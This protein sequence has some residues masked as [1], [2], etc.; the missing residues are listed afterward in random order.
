MEKCLKKAVANFEAFELDQDTLYELWLNTTER[1]YFVRQGKC[2]L[3]FPS[4][5]ACFIWNGANKKIC[6][7]DDWIMLG[8]DLSVEVV[9]KENIVNWNQ[10]ILPN[11]TLKYNFPT[12]VI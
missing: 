12:Q 4:I 7:P 3:G 11:P 8:E 6:K 10:L 9:K 5:M 2:Y 1:K